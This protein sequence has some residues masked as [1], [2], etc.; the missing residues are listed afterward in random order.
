MVGFIPFAVCVICSTNNK[1]GSHYIRFVVITFVVG[2]LYRA[3]VA[4]FID[5]GPLATSSSDSDDPLKDLTQ[6]GLASSIG[7]FLMLWILSY[8]IVTVS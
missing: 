2:M 5:D 6:S 1:Y 8:N 4:D 3:R 7:V